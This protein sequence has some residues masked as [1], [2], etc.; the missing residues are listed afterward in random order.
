MAR[1]GLARPATIYAASQRFQLLRNTGR[2]A[3][4]ETES[5]RQAARWPLL[6]GYRCMLAWPT[7]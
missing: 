4:A 7:E 5:R 3:E 6:V 2:I 1:P